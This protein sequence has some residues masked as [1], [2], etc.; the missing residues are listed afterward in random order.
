MNVDLASSLQLEPLRVVGKG[1]RQLY[2][3]WTTPLMCL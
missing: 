2:P 1:K 3:F